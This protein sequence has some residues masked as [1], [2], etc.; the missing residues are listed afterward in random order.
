MCRPRSSDEP[1]MAS[2][3][4]YRYVDNLCEAIPLEA[5]FEMVSDVRRSCSC[6]GVDDS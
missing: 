3:F 1:A 6:S 4:A 5:D 2:N